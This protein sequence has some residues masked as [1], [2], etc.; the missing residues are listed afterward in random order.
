[1]IA[2]TSWPLLILLGTA[3]SAA[4]L[5]LRPGTYVPAGSPCHDPALAAMFSYDGSKFSYP[6]AS[7]CR[8]TITS[9]AGRTYRISETCSA[10]GDGSASAPSTTLATYTILAHSRVQVSREHNAASPYRW[11]AAVTKKKP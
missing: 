6:H 9:H 4:T 10:L 5:P 2:R 1:M 8:S 3:A 7:D 11:C